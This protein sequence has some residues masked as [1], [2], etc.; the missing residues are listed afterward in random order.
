METKPFQIGFPESSLPAR[1]LPPGRKERSTKTPVKDRPKYYTLAEGTTLRTGPVGGMGEFIGHIEQTAKARVLRKVV[2]EGNVS[3]WV[4]VESPPE[5][6]GKYW[7]TKR[8]GKAR[9]FI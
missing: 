5:Q 1:A 9:G 2:I 6:K 4:E 8:F 3:F 7:I